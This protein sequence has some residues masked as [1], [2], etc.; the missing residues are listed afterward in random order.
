M[1]ENLNFYQILEINNH[2]CSETDIKNQYIKLSKKYHP[3]RAGG[4]E[5]SFKKITEA[6]QTLFDQNKRRDYDFKLK[7]NNNNVNI[8]NTFNN[9]T[10]FRNNLRAQRFYRRNRHRLNIEDF[11]E[12]SIQEAYFGMIK[13]LRIIQ[14][15]FDYNNNQRVTETL[16]EI[17]IE[18]GIKD[19]DQIKLPGQGNQFPDFAG[20]TII[21]IKIKNNTNFIRK[22]DD[23]HYDLNLSLKRSLCGACDGFGLSIT[24]GVFAIVSSGITISFKS[25]WD[26]LFDASNALLSM[27]R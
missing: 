4:N 24:R 26:D 21:T 6:Y 15:L 11:L 7:G 2:K 23:L 13:R 22:G 25:A 18:P 9:N 27:I 3:D 1:F 12:I 17:N 5:E 10:T 16:T 20:D 8:N 19:G 14:N